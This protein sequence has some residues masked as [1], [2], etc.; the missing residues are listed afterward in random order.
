MRRDTLIVL[1]GLLLAAPLAGQDNPFAFTGG[2]VKS[3]YIVYDMTSTKPGA[4]A[5]GSWEMGVGPD[6]WIIKSAMPFE[7]AGKKDTIRSLMVTTRDSQYSYTV[8]GK[9]REGKVSPLL[10]PHLAREYVAL[11]AAG[12][13]RFKE[14]VKLMTSGSSG[15]VGELITLT[16]Q[17]LGSETIGGHKCDIYKHNKVTACVVP[18]APMVMLRWSDEEQGLNMVAKTIKLN[19]PLPPALGLL[20]KGVRWKKESYDDADFVE[21]IWLRKKPE[22][23]PAAVSAPD[24]AKFAVGYLAS[25]AGSAEMRQMVA[26]QQSG[27]SEDDG[28]DDESSEE[29]DTTGS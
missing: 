12:K 9:D 1:G 2:S 5:G 25:P 22:S 14:N 28:A 29:E 15:D 27:S 10:R 17:K 20:P 23:D 3:A 6:R 26:E 8:M 18:G 16:G 19:G 13:T 11:N 24:L 4:T 21:G 7:I